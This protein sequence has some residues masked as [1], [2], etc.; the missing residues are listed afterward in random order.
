MSVIVRDRQGKL[1]IFCKGSFEKVGNVCTAASIPSDYNRVARGHA[2][3][4][5]YVLSV[6]SRALGQLSDADISQLKRA[7]VEHDLELQGLIVFR[8]ELKEDTRDAI[9]EIR[10]WVVFCLYAHPCEIFA[11]CAVFQHFQLLSA[12]L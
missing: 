5:G 4:G 10:V 3:E 7:D 2:L 9:I 12:F 1:Y 6:A 8:N 11:S